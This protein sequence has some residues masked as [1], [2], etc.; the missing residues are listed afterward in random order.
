MEQLL[1]ATKGA[2]CK[3]PEKLISHHQNA[4]YFLKQKQSIFNKVSTF[5]NTKAS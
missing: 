1:L 2:E 4:N 3:F 5:Y